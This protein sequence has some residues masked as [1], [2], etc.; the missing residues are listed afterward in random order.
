MLG[1]TLSCIR[2]NEKLNT[3]QKIK[4]V[5]TLSL[6][7]IMAQVTSII[8]QYIDA[9]MVGSL[10]ASSSASIGLV[11]TTTWL[12]GSLASAPSLGFSIQVAQFI[13]AKK[14]K[15]A[16]Q[17][18]MHS[19]LVVFLIAVFIG[20]I[21]AAISG[22][23][24]AWLG[25]KE[26]IRAEATDY[27]LVVSLTLPAMGFNRLGTRMLQSCGNTKV[28]GI[29][30]AMNCLLDI[31][32]NYFFIFSGEIFGIRVGMGLGV[33]GAALG[34]AAAEVVTTIIMFYVLM[35][36]TPMLSKNAS[37][38]APG[39]SFNRV[40]MWCIKKAF[41]LSMPVIFENIVMFGAMI[42][43]TR[44]IAPL[45][46]VAVAANSFAITA[47]SLCYMPAYGIEEAATALV[48]QSIGAGRGKLAVSFGRISVAFGMGIMAVT[49]ILMFIFA[50]FMIGILTPDA[51]V[52]ELGVRILR[53]EA[54]AEPL[55]GA[56]IVVTGVLR[57]AGDTLVSSILN[58]ISLWCVRVV[59][60][61]L[62]VGSYG[63]VGVW[64]AMAVELMFRGIIFLTRME[65]KKWLNKNAIS[66]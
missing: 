43:I 49:G 28:P 25:G 23:L 24:P 1:D 41:V 18:L 4:L 50:P 11:S 65:R 37:K 36:R 22:A 56:S 59:L 12:L 16:R 53:I 51:E 9:A 62:L 21:G 52:R 66:S 64:V 38:S 6:P 60:S 57:G 20:A 58:F 2:N 33:M 19:F 17:V 47:E 7:T 29:L 5:A 30:N 45:G 31:I 55:Y 48:G 3:N 10:G 34:T 44:V 39:N 61:F 26:I 32:F 54:F 46:V 8:M 15:E 40:Q 63:L 13:G 14:F 42:T 35:C 27:F